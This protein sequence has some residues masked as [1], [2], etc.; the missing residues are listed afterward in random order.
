MNNIDSKIKFLTE[1]TSKLKNVKSLCNALGTEDELSYI[2]QR[3]NDNLFR[4]S[5]V[6]E[7]SSGKS[8]FINA[9]IGKDI[10]S[11]AVS[12]TTAAITYIYN[13]SE[14]DSRNGTCVIEYRNGKSVN[15]NTLE[16]IKDYTTV[17]S[18]NCVA[19]SI[20]SVTVFVHF[21]TT[22]YPVLIT[23]TP[24]LNGIARF[25]EE[26]TINEVKKSHMCVYLL[27]L[28]GITNSDRSFIKMLM[29]YQSEFLFL[30]NF[31]DELRAHEGET[32]N[33]KIEEAEMIIKENFISEKS[34][35]KYKIIGISALKALAAKDKNVKKIYKDDLY[36]LN[37]DKRKKAYTESNFSEFE[38]YLESLI[39]SGEYRRVVADSAQTRIMAIVNAFLEKLN[40]QQK[41]NSELREGDVKT[42]RIKSAQALIELMDKNKEDKKRRLNNFIISENEKMK[43]ELY[44]YN[45]N[46]VV[47]IYNSV[48]NEIDEKIRKYEE[49]DNFKNTYKKSPS[50]YFT[51]RADALLK[52]YTKSDLISNIKVNINILLDEAVSRITS[53]T[54]SSVHNFHYKISIQEF[55]E[56]FKMD[57]SEHFSLIEE[58]KKEIRGCE[59]SID[60]Y[61]SKKASRQNDLSYAYDCLNDAKNELKNSKSQRDKAIGSLGK[62][63]DIER[64]VVGTRYVNAPRSGLFGWFH[65][66]FAVVDKRLEN[67]YGDDDTKQK[68]WINRRSELMD[69][70]E[71]VI[72]QKESEVSDAECEVDEIN[73]DISYY[74]REINRLKNKIKSL[75][76]SIENEN[77]IFDTILKMNKQQF[78][79]RKKN[80][81]KKAIENK[82]LSDTSSSIIES[83]K[84]FISDELDRNIP[85][86]QKQ[87]VQFFEQSFSEQRNTLEIMIKENNR[88]LEER[89]DCNKKDMSILTAVLN[90]IQSAK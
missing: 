83:L 19:E 23:D 41:I 48:C 62:K 27:S 6:G 68:E 66:T 44:K 3:L 51:Q 84:Q 13:V 38:K 49:Y 1:Q 63:P 75:K 40:E 17:Q 87:A 32:I 33:N 9:I 26:I 2:E 57:D 64:V 69:S 12:E 39:R 42:E 80:E 4:I 59:E 34:S 60:S 18:G 16:N 73:D 53:Y 21:L 76:V 79:E 37:D 56:I 43:R 36:E 89:Y 30:Q 29:N 72:R 24:G 85:M 86:I 67:V 31:K 22:G 55:P 15:V 82:L 71:P 65:D 14:S 35:F 28:K 54:N 8:T 88:Q 61:K 5:V 25:H 45:N 58:Y 70:F 20:K 7:F 81:I 77:Q 50:L 47:E 52:K 10:L 74:D 90:N 78:C 11:H 46:S